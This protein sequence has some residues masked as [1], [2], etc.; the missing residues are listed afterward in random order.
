[1]RF[2]KRLSSNQR[3]LIVGGAAVAAIWLGWPSIKSTIGSIGHQLSGGLIAVAR[4]LDPSGLPP[5]YG[6][7]PGPRR[8]WRS[9]REG[10]YGEAPE[11]DPLS[12]GEG[13]YTESPG[14]RL[15]LP[16]G[17]SLRRIDNADSSSRGRQGRPRRWRYC[18]ERPGH[19]QQ[20]G[21]WQAG[22]APEGE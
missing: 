16:P 21:P 1:M 22:P 7:D 4:T 19:P 2:W 20:C 5:R 9:R 8:G 11:Q 3:L 10:D 6:Y 12:R 15:R 18:T 14:R 17:P 13:D